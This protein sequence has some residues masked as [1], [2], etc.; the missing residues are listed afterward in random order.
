MYYYRITKY[1]PKLRNEKGWYT[2][3]EWTDFSCVGHSFGGEL[4]TLENYEYV[5]ALH[6]DAVLLFMDSMNLDYLKC[7][8]V[9]KYET[10]KDEKVPDELRSLYKRVKKGLCIYK[11]EMRILLKLILR[12]YFWCKLEHSDKMFVHFGYEYYMYVGVEKECKEVV[13]QIEQSGLFVEEFLSPYLDDD[14]DL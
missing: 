1:D 10:I 13:D 7:I 4:C 2:K 6:I 12:N 3:D 9:E 11:N 5:E 8:G 14:E